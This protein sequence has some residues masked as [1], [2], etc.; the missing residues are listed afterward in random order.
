[1]CGRFEN[2]ISTED[3][4]SHL[5]LK[6]L[7]PEPEVSKTNISPTQ[8]IMTLV[9][10]DDS[11]KYLPMKWGIKF[12]KESPLIFNSRIETIKEK[13]YWM[14]IFKAS[15]CIV[16]MSAFY[17]WKT[18]GDKKIPFR[19]FL[20]DEKIFF[21]PAVF[22]EHENELFASFITTPPNE[23]I[24]KIHHRMPVILRKDDAIDFLKC[25]DL[26]VNLEKC[27]PFKDI[28]DMAM[29]RITL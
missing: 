4:F 16:P 23:F 14:N 15:R 24:K 12:S 13:P 6:D 20:K 29:E 22:I 11:L 2:I 21:V 5:E 9:L 25:D 26:T 17:E 7:V 8:K 28:D 1:M 10:K 27:T 19:I 18:E 3:L